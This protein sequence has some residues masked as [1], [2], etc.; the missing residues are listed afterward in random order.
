MNAYLRGE[1]RT[2]QLP[3]GESLVGTGA[4]CQM[5]LDKS[6]YPEVS[7]SHAK[8]M[9][10]GGVVSFRDENSANGT[11]KNG[12]RLSAGELR[13]GDTLE[14]GTGGPVFEIRRPANGN[15]DM[16]T[17]VSSRA[18]FTPTP[19]PVVHPPAP[20]PGHDGA[21]RMMSPVVGAGASRDSVTR[22]HPSPKPAGA[23][24][25]TNDGRTVVV[26]RDGRT[27]PPQERLAQAETGP[28]QASAQAE[29]DDEDV[30][31]P[32]PQPVAP[33]IVEPDRSL[34]YALLRKVSV[35]QQMLGATLAAAVI[36]VALMIFQ[37][38]EIAAN[39][40]AIEDLQKQASSSVGLLMPQ[41][42]ERLKHLDTRLDGLDP[43]LQSAEDHMSERMNQEV[44]RMMDKYLN[45]RMSS[46]QAKNPGMTLP[47]GLPAIPP[48]LIPGKQ[49]GK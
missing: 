35:L 28:V 8:L 19:A 24:A 22:I 34:E 23:G 41:L 31:V 29:E 40:D 17:R 16:A 45:Q 32:A 36:L 1:D 13:P 6:R 11:L 30:F 48:G 10:R 44:P 3:E 49:P 4:D 38:R 12:V 20:A 18:V 15:A 42:D 47:A 7:R 9:V 43:K 39:K 25:S 26:G 33:T 21:T 5:M 46:V 27:P 14:L 2:F 37:D